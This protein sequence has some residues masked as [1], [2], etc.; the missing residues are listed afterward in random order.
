MNSLCQDVRH[1]IRMLCKSPGFT[2]V[3]VLIL[4]VAIGANTAVF[5]VVN[6]VVL[7]PLPYRDADRIVTLWEQTK[8]GPRRPSHQD[9]RSWYRP[10]QVF[11]SIAAYGAERFYVAGI[12]K[13][14]EVRAGTVSSDLF[15]L[16]GIEPVLGRGFLPEEE[17][18]G[19]DRVV[20]LSHRFWRDRL[21]ADPNALGR[22]ISLTSDNMNPDASMS[23]DRRDYT[24]VGIMPAD[25][26]FPF[27]RPAP[28]WVPLVFTQDRVWKQ[29][30]PVSPIA[31]LQQRVTLDQARA[32]MAVVTERARQAAPEDRGDRTIGL[33][34]LHNRIL[35]GNRRLLLLLLGAAG[36]V[37]LIACGNVANLFLARATARQHEVATRMVLGASRSRILRQMLT[38]SLLLTV[39]AGLVGLLLTVLTVKGL[40]GLCPADV[41]RLGQ[42]TVDSTVLAFTIGVSV[43]TG[44]LF[45]T[46]PAWRPA[47]TRV[48]QTLKE[49]WTRPS[50]TRRRRRLRG[51]LAVLQIGLSLILLVGAALLIRSLIALQSLNLG[52]QLENVLTAEIQL[53]TAKY[54]TAQHCTT[55][56][57]GL[58][59]H[60]RRLP[61]VRSAA[62]VHSGLQFGA[63]EADIPFSVP[64]RPVSDSEETPWAK[65]ICMSPDLFKTMGIQLLK[66]RDLTDQ[67]GADR[68][69]IDETLARRYFGDDDPVGRTLVHDV[70]ARMTIVGVV[71]T[72]RDFLT[73]DPAEGAIYMRMGANYQGM[74]LVARTVDDPVQV[75]PLLRQ[76]IAALSEEEVISRIEPLDTTLSETLAPRR[77]VMILLGLFGGMALVVA[78]IGVYGLL[79]YSTTQQTHD[80]GVRMALG[81]REED[82]LIAVL[83]QGIKLALIGV[84]AGLI[85]ALALTRVLSSLLYDVTAT[86]PTTLVT[87]S[88]ILAAMALLASYLPARRAAKVDPMEAL[89]YE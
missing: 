29:G 24:I 2:A 11:E 88:I 17:Q 81:A 14:R 71:R 79:Q 38:E 43:L 30:R 54:P 22:T 77:F 55:F 44:L 25:F 56:Y 31:R 58:L 12:D 42:T 33:D 35:A 26:E 75:A 23:F 47:G 19:N 45:A 83:G 61:Q 39:G 69:V 3:V 82:V 57:N 16:L 36:F 84:A 7:K 66:G 67:D 4:A 85:G 10:S 89:R 52:F 8:W 59:D 53:P 13:S 63:A 49:G 87:V 64:G 86:D 51:S 68:I 72:T 28:F 6:A 76:A 40:V 15:P 20:V 65:W 37:L 70:M 5:S 41:P 73:P 60:V 62:L 50:I 27:G 9:F 18:A 46:M 78:M 1:G 48:S 32:E 21:G 34:R 74:V 80:I